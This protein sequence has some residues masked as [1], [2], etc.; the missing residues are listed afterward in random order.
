MKQ[1]ERKDFIKKELQA[2]YD[3]F[4]VYADQINML[5]PF[6]KDLIDV[7]NGAEPTYDLGNFLQ[8]KKGIK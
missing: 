5:K 4:S 2:V 6:I 3:E 1:K 7:A 8:N